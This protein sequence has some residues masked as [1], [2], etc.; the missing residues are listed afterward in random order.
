M[1]FL[2][3]FVFRFSFYCL[4]VLCYSHFIVTSC[5]CR[6]VFCTHNNN[7]N[8]HHSSVVSHREDMAD[9]SSRVGTFVVA[10]NSVHTV[11]TAPD[12]GIR[13]PQLQ[14]ALSSAGTGGS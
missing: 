5:V 13:H 1:I 3:F 11:T 4:H 14:P 9:D 10:P 7:N 6:D 2:C 12:D 8:T